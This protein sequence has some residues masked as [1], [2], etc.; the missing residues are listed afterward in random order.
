MHCSVCTFKRPTSVALCRPQGLGRDGEALLYSCRNDCRT[1]VAA[2]GCF[3]TADP[4][5]G[6]FLFNTSSAPI[7]VEFLATISK[8]TGLATLTQVPRL[9]EA[10]AP[11]REGEVAL[12]AR[13][14]APLPPAGEGLVLSS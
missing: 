7:S 12:R 11:V 4:A 9:P 2:R 10:G 3:E 6:F 8:S 13:L 14:F 5:H 1:R